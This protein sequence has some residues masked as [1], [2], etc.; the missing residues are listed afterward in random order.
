MSFFFTLLRV[1]IEPL[2]SLSFFVQ[3]SVQPYGQK[4]KG[5]LV[6]LTSKLPEAVCRAI[7]NHWPISSWPKLDFLCRFYRLNRSNIPGMYTFTGKGM[8]LNSSG[9]S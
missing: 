3:L 8:H 9:F 2:V 7:L 6:V 4:R 1:Q 5:S